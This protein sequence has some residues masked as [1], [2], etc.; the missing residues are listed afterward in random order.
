MSPRGNLLGPE[1]SKSEDHMEK[2]QAMAAPNAVPETRPVEAEL[3]RRAA[4]REEEAIRAIIKQ[5]NARLFRLARSVLRHDADAEDALQVG[6][7][8]AFAAMASFRGDS[9]LNTWLSR[10]V[11]NECL[12]RLRNGRAN[13][14]ATVALEPEMEA[15]IIPFPQAGDPEKSVAQRELVALV[16]SAIDRLPDDFR[17]VLVARTIE[18]L[19]VE[20][21]AT[22]LDLRPETV[23][24]RLFR[25][26]KMLKSAMTDHLDP[27][28]MNT[29]PFLGHRCERIANA[30]VTKLLA[31]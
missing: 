29:F 9:S 27:L 17:L 31:K 6:Y 16:E 14:R 13:R 23:K 25:A 26:R 18:G 12:Q 15:Q 4:N 3:V 20:E 1:A 8:K 30:V 28:L 11:M 24:T 2:G 5:H 22:L 19:S 21:T 7:V 10:I